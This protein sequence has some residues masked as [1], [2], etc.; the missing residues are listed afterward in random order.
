MHP[1]GATPAPR[2]AL[3]PGP[4]DRI[5][6][7]S[8][9]WGERPGWTWRGERPRGAWRWS[10]MPGPPAPEGAARAP[11]VERGTP[12]PARA[13]GAGPT[14]VPGTEPAT[15]PGR[16]PRAPPPWVLTPRAP[17]SAASR[18]GRQTCLHNEPAGPRRAAAAATRPIPA[19]SP[20][21]SR[22]GEER[23]RI[24]PDPLAQ[25]LAHV[26]RLGP[27]GDARR[28]GGSR[29]RRP[30]LQTALLRGRRSR[31][32]APA[33]IAGHAAVCPGPAPVLLGDA[34]V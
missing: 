18:R 8:R 3:F 26:R 19:A 4:P 23:R 14:R 27:R 28:R 22:P 11:R 6:P 15:P 21:G 13:L 7:Q 12:E 20:G 17:P 31:R 1:R 25:Q 16:A 2:R 9:T 5:L 34:P 32:A 24:A 10:S 29:T 30:R 33:P